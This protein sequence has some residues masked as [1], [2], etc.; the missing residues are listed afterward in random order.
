MES[1][2]H[3][4]DGF[5]EHGLGGCGDVLVMF[6]DGF[7]FLAG[8]AES[9]DELF[10]EIS[11]A[12]SG[13]VVASKPCEIELV[14][15]V[16]DADD[17]SKFV[18]VFG[19]AVGGEAHDFV[20]VAGAKESE[21]VGDGAVEDAEGVGVVDVEL[22]LDGGALADAA[23][24]GCELADVVDGEDGGGVVGTD[25]ERAG[26]VGGVVVHVDDGAFPIE[27]STHTAHVFEVVCEF[28]A[29]VG[30]G[31]EWVAWHIAEAIGEALADAIAGAH[32]GAD[33]VDVL[34]GE[35]GCFEAELGGAVGDAALMFLTAE[36]L[37]G[38]RGDQ[39]A[40]ADE[41]CGRVV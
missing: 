27:K 28:V 32:I 24:G 15:A 16:A 1:I 26:G 23:P 21:V 11:T 4:E 37:F 31:V 35:T 3:G 18:E 12:R 36:A 25:E 10:G 41:G 7:D 6:G 14:G 33:G 19:R 9:V 8:W 39:F 13:G 34:G 17:V 22:G 38:D 2:G 20:F 30:G 40:I 5:F 29:H